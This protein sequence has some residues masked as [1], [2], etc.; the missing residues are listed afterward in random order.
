MSWMS[1]STVSEGSCAV[2]VA[3]AWRLTTSPSIAVDP[4]DDDGDETG[5]EVH[6]DRVA[7][8]ADQAQGRARLAPAGAGAPRLF[9]DPRVEESLHDVRDGLRGQAGGV[10]QL[11]TAVAVR[12]TDL[13]QHDRFVVTTD[14]GLICAASGHG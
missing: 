1:T 2:G 7:A 6:A 3:R 10:G 9:H 4:E 14:A 8:A 13:V 5:I 12:T 11:D